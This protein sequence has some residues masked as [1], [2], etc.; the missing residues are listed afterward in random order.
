MT[1]I[2]GLVGEKLAGKDV[3]GNYLASHHRAFYIKYSQL[4]GEILNILDIP[5]SRENEILL[6][7]GL[8]DN[9][10][11]NVLWQGMKKRIEESTNEIKVIGSIRLEDEF[12]AAK[13]LGAK[14]I[15]I[16]APAP[17]RYERFMHRRE[18]ADDGTQSMEEF[19][20]KELGWTEVEIPKL[21]AKC[22][23]AIENT[24]TMQDLYEKIDTML[25]EIKNP[26]TVLVD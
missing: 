26:G 3:M 23:F 20:Q 19:I 25:A 22:D 18:K 10:Q 11:K 15:Y 14:M 6:G 5:I 24:G 1:L 8:R 7:K 16:T 2:L 4:L 17:T 21:G 9:F 13:E 12:N